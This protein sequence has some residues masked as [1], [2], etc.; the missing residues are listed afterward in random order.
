MLEEGNS[1]T[2]QERHISAAPQLSKVPHWFNNEIQK[3]KKL[4]KDLSNR[5]LSVA[6]FKCK[7]ACLERL[8]RSSDSMLKLQDWSIC[9]RQKASLVSIRKQVKLYLKQV[10]WSHPGSRLVFL[11]LL[12]TKSIIDNQ[13]GAGFGCLRARWRRFI[14]NLRFLTGLKWLQPFT[15]V[16]LLPTIFFPVGKLAS[17]DAYNPPLQR[18]IFIT[19]IILY[20]KYSN[21][22]PK[23]W[24]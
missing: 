3:L 4:K 23:S 24:A 8:H 19:S 5:G 6:R 7:P 21:P 15:G 18:L 1:A 2:L 9:Q 22:D 13:F 17:P 12:Q 14:P 16:G 10:K 11:F 20:N